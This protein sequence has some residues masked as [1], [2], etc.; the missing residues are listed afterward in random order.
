MQ[1]YSHL[2]VSP[3]LYPWRQTG[4]VV[5]VVGSCALLG[6]NID[7]MKRAPESGTHVEPRHVDSLISFT[8]GGSATGP[9][10]PAF[11]QLT[12]PVAIPKLEGAEGQRARSMRESALSWGAQ[13]G[14]ARRIW[15]ITQLYEH[16]QAEL[17][18]VWN[19]RRVAS[20]APRNT[21]WVLPPVVRVAGPAWSG[22]GSAATAVDAYYEIIKPGRIVGSL[23]GWHDYLPRAA[24]EPVMPHNALLPASGEEAQWREWAAEGWL[25][26]R[27][28]ANDLLEVSLV[29]LQRDH[30]GMLEYR[31]MLA[32]DMIS[33][34]VLDHASFV[35]SAEDDGQVLRIGERSVRI[36]DAAGFITDTGQWRPVIVA[37]DQPGEGIK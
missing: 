23:P 28:Q 2:P 8:A 17:D 3:A 4:L 32:Q 25:A 26:G 36:V 15:E 16:R 12:L 19:F 30:G 18:E 22:T 10:P 6:C 14:Y 34:I 33:S 7:V 31:R 29:R 11:D 24:P 21:G 5:L 35:P 37:T 13:A 20:P 9:E 27:E 1:M